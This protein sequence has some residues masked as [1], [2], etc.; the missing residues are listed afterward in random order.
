MRYSFINM[1][2]VN[3]YVARAFVFDI[4]AFIRYF[5]FS[6]GIQQL[7]IVCHLRIIKTTQQACKHILR[8]MFYLK[9]CKIDNGG[10]SYQSQTLL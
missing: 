6:F 3:S 5:L 9:L 1:N 2:M 4:F 8:K 10:I 7:F